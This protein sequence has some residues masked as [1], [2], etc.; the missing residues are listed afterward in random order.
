MTCTSKDSRRNVSTDRQ[1]KRD[2]EVGCVTR[3][4]QKKKGYRH[5]HGGGHSKKDDRKRR[6]FQPK[7]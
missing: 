7:R 3:A 6:G 1:T 4:L 5:I 2:V